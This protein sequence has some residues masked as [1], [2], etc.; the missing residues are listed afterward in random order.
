MEE[1][2]QKYRDRVNFLW[3]YSREAHPEERPFAAGF[4]T[5]D[6]GWD[7]RYFEPTTMEERAQRARWMKT[8]LEPDLE[9][10]IIIDYINS[11]LGE[12][13]A[14]WN[15][16]R[17]GGFYSGF[18]ID[19]DGT[20][21][22]QESWAWFAP[23]GQWWG[24]PLE[25]VSSIETFL[26][27]YLA[28]PPP[29]YNQDSNL[30]DS[31]TPSTPEIVSGASEGLPTVLIVDDDGGSSYEGY[32]KIPLGNLKKHFQVWDVE[33][34]GSPSSDILKSYE[35]VVWLTGDMSQDTLTSTD[36][37]SLA[38]FLDGG[39]KLL[40]SG[41]NIGHDI[42]DTPF[43]R[44]YLHATLIEDDTN[45]SRLS[46]EDILS[47]IEVTLFGNDGA[48][49]QEAPS[50]IGLLDSAV[51]V[52][53]YDTLGLPSWG[54]L[55]WEGDYKVVYLAFGFEG[56]GDRGAGAFRFKILKEVFAWFG[57]LET[58][59]TTTTTILQP[60]TTVT[61]SMTTTIGTHEGK[62]DD[63]LCLICHDISFSDEG[64]HGIHMNNDCTD[65]HE[66]VGDSPLASK[67]ASCHPA[68]DPGKCM[69]VLH[70]EV[71]T[72]DDP[73][74]L[75]CLGCHSECSGETS[76]TTTSIECPLQEIYGEDSKETE[77]LRY[78]RDEVL[79]KTKEGK[80]ITR[81]YYEWSPAIVK[82]MKEDVEFKIKV[83]EMIDGTLPLILEEE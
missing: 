15:V 43:Y 22:N 25:Q 83:R 2:Y 56:I 80:E 75:T 16:Y 58:D 53:R 39:G 27:S 71:S 1:L 47:G 13:N 31:L 24:L 64:L 40:L 21:L 26:D 63:A 3:A 48:G 11:P 18:V 45:I 62:V 44:D 30:S 42:G 32:F 28:D 57:D 52:F 17:G 73:S 66:I 72:N 5:K 76:S 69:L 70:H 38:S 81:L 35:S 60:T 79:S 37:T 7:H 55:L 34:S 12:D 78:F 23:G 10:P 20:V 41:Q 14:I 67:C 36:Q 33:E 51:G 65:C 29:C 68:G 82:V 74:N 77:L 50:Q 46:G 6:L 54:G 9:I 49:N 19:C 8:D 4:E 59:T 61:G